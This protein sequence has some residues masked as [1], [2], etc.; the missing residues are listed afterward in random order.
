VTQHRATGS[1]TSALWTDD[2]SSARTLGLFPVGAEDEEPAPV[3]TWL[4]IIGVGV[5]TAALGVA[6][7]VLY[8]L[9]SDDLPRDPDAV[10]VLGGA[11]D[12]VEL[13]VELAERYD[14]ELVL[15]SSAAI[16]GEERGRRCGVD[17]ICV[18]P[19]PENTAGEAATIA[20][21][22]QEQGWSHV[23][24]ATADFHTARAR[25]LFR[26]CLGRA[27]VT[28]VGAPTERSSGRMLLQES[29]KTIAGATTHRA[30]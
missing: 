3:R 24:V 18:E 10:V 23:T 5:V 21:M 26:Q 13:G 17:S 30:C 7:F 27:N 16:L 4:V 6:A 29:L 25:Y 1:T 9:P 19:E 12:R 20:R 11:G 22:A 8:M 15:S 2:W 28:V 14:A